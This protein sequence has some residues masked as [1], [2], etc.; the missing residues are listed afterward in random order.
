[1]RAL[2]TGAGGFVGRHLVAHLHARGDDVRTFDREST[3][4]LD[5]TDPLAVEEAITSTKPHAIYHLAALSH[6]GESWDAPVRVLR[7]NIEGTLHVLRAAQTAGGARVVVVGSADEYGA[8]DERDLPL[9]E[10]APL[11][12]L[13][14]YGVS[15]VAADYLALQ[16]FLAEGLETI[17]VRAFNHIGPGQA[18]RFLLPGLA[19]RI[20]EA[21]RDGRDEIV[22]GNLDAIRDL[23]DVRDVVAAYRLLAERGEPGEAYNVCSGR[24]LAV[25]EIAARLL[26]RSDRPLRLT[27]DPALVRAIEVPQLVGDCTKLQRATGWT[28]AIDL[29]A[30]LDE[31]LEEARARVRAADV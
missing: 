11:R 12:P 3:P 30:T 4:S 29:E 24:G 21:E 1:M 14:P 25:S 26:A 5:V 2:V 17:R 13:T 6:V 8:V 22:V 20:A 23:T 10:T 28:R 9:R 16:A 31:V 7:V 19:Q 18:P 15:K 27:V